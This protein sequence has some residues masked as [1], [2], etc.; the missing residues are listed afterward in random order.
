MVNRRRFI[1]TVI[2][3]AL[4]A[5]FLPLVASA[6]G[7]YDPWGRRDRRNNDDWRYGRNDNRGLR[8][9]ARRLDDRSGDFQRHLDSALD[10]SRIDDTR[11]EDNINNMAR[12]F[13]HAASNFRDRV[14][15]GRNLSRASNEAHRLLQIGSRLDGIVQRV[16]D[17]RARSDW[18]QIR[19]DLR[20]VGNAYGINY[21]GGGYGR[22]DGYYGRDDD[23][24]RNRR[25]DRRNNN[26]EWWRR[27]PF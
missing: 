25:N 17:S 4:I 10:R 6:Q 2:S 5:L 14:D 16:G 27:L 9:V 15:D 8:D 7:G 19:Q 3:A 18:A 13:R 21:S 1:P 12:E 24:Y 20:I 11:R 26:N 22:N 23:R